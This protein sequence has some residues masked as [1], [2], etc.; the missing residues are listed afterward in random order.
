MLICSQPFMKTERRIEDNQQFTVETEENLYLYSDRIVTPT[1]T[2]IMKE[3]LDM[4]SKPLSAYYTFLYL[5][6]IEGVRTFV[7]KS[8]PE[9]FISHYHQVK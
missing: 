7:V 2:F 1:R 6:T 3:V 4:T 5:H 9:R 8:S